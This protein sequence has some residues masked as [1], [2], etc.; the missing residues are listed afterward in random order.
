MKMRVRLCETV[1]DRDDERIIPS[2][3][4]QALLVKKAVDRMISVFK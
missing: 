4:F 1:I 3:E 2:L